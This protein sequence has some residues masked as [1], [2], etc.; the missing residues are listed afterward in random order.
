M[1]SVTCVGIAIMDLV[2]G[3]ENLPTGSGKQFAREFLEIGGG[4][5]ATAAVAA[6]RLGAICDLWARVG[7]DAT[8]DKIIE[9]LSGYGVETSGIRRMDGA[10]STL[11]A[12]IVDDT[13]ERAIVSYTDSALA[14]DASWLP[15]DSLADTGCVLADCRW[16]AAVKQVFPKAEA[17][18]VPTLLDGDLTPDSAV[19]ELAPLA[20]HL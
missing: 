18:G 1:T 6:A 15:M 11:A 9:E 4:P 14:T 10:R 12:V 2:F 13:G 17:L 8:G 19:R 5:A 16:V 20:S 3:V 7:V